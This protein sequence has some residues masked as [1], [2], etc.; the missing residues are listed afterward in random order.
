[1]VAVYNKDENLY[2]VIQLTKDEMID[3]ISVFNSCSLAEKRRFYKLREDI[4]KLVVENYGS[5]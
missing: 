2:G 4:I 3:L 5:D 1:M